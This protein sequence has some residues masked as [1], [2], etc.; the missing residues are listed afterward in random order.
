MFGLRRRPDK[1]KSLA[2]INDS[3]KKLLVV[4]LNPVKTK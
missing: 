1:R 3:K 4:K 2:K